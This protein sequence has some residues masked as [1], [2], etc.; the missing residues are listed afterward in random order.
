[1]AVCTCMHWLSRNPAFHYFISSQMSSRCSV[2]LTIFKCNGL[3]SK[4][5][6]NLLRGNQIS[7]TAIPCTTCTLVFDVGVDLS[8]TAFPCCSLPCNAPW[9]FYCTSFLGHGALGSGCFLSVF[10]EESGGSSLLQY[11][12]PVSDRCRG[13]YKWEQRQCG[14]AQ[15]MLCREDFWGSE[16]FSYCPVIRPPG[17]NKTRLFR[18][19]ILKMDPHQHDCSFTL[20]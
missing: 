13:R 17:E 12:I 18:T 7:N 20:I 2:A 11:C 6:L 15:L 5:F 14:I 9:Q 10:V 19:D 1:M 3:H 8:A 16:G 4:L